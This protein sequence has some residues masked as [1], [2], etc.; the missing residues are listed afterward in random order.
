MLQSVR[1]SEVLACRR[2]SVEGWRSGPAVLQSAD[3]FEMNPEPRGAAVQNAGPAPSKG[4][5]GSK[6]GPPTSQ[7][8]E[9][10]A[11][12]PP[13]A[14]R[15]VRCLEDRSPPYAVPSKTEAG[16]ALNKRGPS[17]ESRWRWYAQRR[18]GAAGAVL[19]PVRHESGGV[20]PPPG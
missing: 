19:T 9:V 8:V 11:G 6:C 1:A 18:A 15:R 10:R 7:D 3:G 12:S 13:P 14:E 17:F 5:P 20:A 16:G 2:E 4:G